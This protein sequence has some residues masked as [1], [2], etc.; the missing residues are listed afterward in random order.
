[1][2]DMQ[3]IVE[4]IMAKAFEDY[5]TV[6][7]GDAAGTLYAAKKE[8]NQRNLINGD[9]YYHRLGMCLNG[10]KGL[11]SSLYS[12]FGGLLN[13]AK[14]VGLKSYDALKSDKPFWP[15]FWEIL[16]DSGKDMKNNFEGSFWGLQNPDKSC[17]I[18]LKDLDINTNSWR[19]K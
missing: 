5:P 9:N 3:E 7:M 11:E 18:W 12:L 8:L 16:K 14:D 19:N 2:A 17:R 15:S 4:N 6:K 13:E 10:Q 1:M